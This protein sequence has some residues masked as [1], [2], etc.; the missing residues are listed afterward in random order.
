MPNNLLRKILYKINS[1]IKSWRFSKKQES[2]RRRILDY[3]HNNPTQDVEIKQAVDYLSKHSLSNFYGSFQE[4]YSYKDVDVLVDNKNGLPY[5]LAEGKKLYFKRSQNKRTVQLMF[6]GLRIEQ[7][8][9]APHCYTDDK[10]RIETNDILADIGC[11][12]AYFSLLNIEKLKKLYLF[13]QDK[14]WIEALEATFRAWKDKVEIVQKYVS[15]RNSDTEVQL[16]DFFGDK[17]P[18]PNFYK[19]DVEG[20]EKSVI[21]GMKEILKTKPLKVALCT[22]HHAEDF[23]L[24]S[25]FFK[26]NGFEYRA[27]PGLMIYQNNIDIMQ[28]PFFRKCLIKADRR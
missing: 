24:F 8:N 15:D 26:E 7:D 22:Y 17:F 4:K 12:E 6:N 9:E 11:A 21:D 23:A 18:L 19:I 16:D 13:E 2:L 27:N 14:E 3:Y 25:Q 20:A 5:V 28:P 1:T 10:F